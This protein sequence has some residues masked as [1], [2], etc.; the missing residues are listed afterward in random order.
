MRDGRRAVEAMVRQILGGSR[1]DTIAGMA[2]GGRTRCLPVPLSAILGLAALAGLSEAAVHD[3]GPGRGLTNIGDVPWESLAAGDE[4]RIHWRREPY[5]EKWVICCRG[6][7]E[8]PICIRGVPGPDGHLPVVTGRGATTRRELD[9]WGEARAVI[10]IGGAN[11]PEDTT[12]SHIVI[13]GLEVRSGRPPFAFSGR[14]GQTPY[15]ENC[16]AIWVEK[17]EHITVRGCVLHDCGNGLM[18]SYQSRDV[19]V[20]GCHVYGNGMEGSIYH[21]NIYTESRGITFQFNQLEPLR[22]GCPGNNLKDRSCGT[23]VRYNWIRGGNRLLDLVDSGHAEL[24]VDPSYRETL[25]YGN[26]LWEEDDGLNNQACHYGGDSGRREAYRKGVLRFFHNTLVSHRSGRTVAFRLST[27]DES[28][29]CRNS[30]LFAKPRGLHLLSGAGR[31]TVTGTWLPDDVRTKGELA[32]GVADGGG[33]VF[34]QSPDLDAEAQ[35]RLATDSSCIDA[36]PP[37]P[38]NLLREHGLVWEYVPHR[39]ARK[40]FIDA[41]P[42]IGAWELV[43]RE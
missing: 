6:T 9:F 1:S 32:D 30:I 20:E 17:G 38:G 16:A 2:P 29:D 28:C 3:V 21:H 24:N 26:F 40:R 39:K 23:A 8:H 37:L 5:R 42:D 43:K 12:P 10:K 36:A 15:G 4:V 35:W 11:T 19:L 13:E 34:G 31:L 18:T 7:V 25:V 14:N 33:N 22:E 27:P 41:S